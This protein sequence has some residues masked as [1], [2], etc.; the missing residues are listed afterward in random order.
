MLSLVNILKSIENNTTVQGLY[1]NDCGLEIS[2]E[3]T[4]RWSA[5]VECVKH[6]CSLMHLELQ[7]NKMPEILTNSIAK[8]LEMN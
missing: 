1:F 6:N 2:V 5:V 4:F 8:E 3:D 7:G